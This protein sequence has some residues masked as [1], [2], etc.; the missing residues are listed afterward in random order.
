MKSRLYIFLWV[1]EWQFYAV[2]AL[3]SDEALLECLSKKGWDPADMV[4]LGCLEGP[5]PERSL[6]KPA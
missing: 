6:L 3:H 4:Y 1:P 2:E 5:L